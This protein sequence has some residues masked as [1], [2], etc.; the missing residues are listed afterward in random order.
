MDITEIQKIIEDYYEH[1]FTNKLDNL[2]EMG[3]IV[4]IYNLP[5]MDH[6]E[7]EH[8]KRP[9]TSKLYES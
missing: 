1:L 2:E 9:I 8:L 7:I 6:E 5:R 4:E 3:T